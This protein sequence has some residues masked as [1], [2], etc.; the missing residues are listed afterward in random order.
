MWGGLSRGGLSRIP[1]T[2]EQY[3]LAMKMMITLVTYI[4]LIC[5]HLGVSISIANGV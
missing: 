3:S 1:P 4:C 2:T 5:A